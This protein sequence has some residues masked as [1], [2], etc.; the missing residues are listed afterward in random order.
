[1]KLMGD[2][3]STDLKH[4]KIEP[5]EVRR[6][7]PNTASADIRE[8]RV[9]L[10]RVRFGETKEVDAAAARTVHQSTERPR[11]EPGARNKRGRPSKHSNRTGQTKSG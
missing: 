4:L 3:R 2:L 9:S 11:L 7:H 5:I 1:M 6:T 10:P 8:M